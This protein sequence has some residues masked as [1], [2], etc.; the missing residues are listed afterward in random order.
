M[1]QGGKGRRV[2]KNCFFDVS[3][4]VGVDARTDP[5]VDAGIRPYKWSR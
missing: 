4:L 5:Q 2:L 1:G 3:C